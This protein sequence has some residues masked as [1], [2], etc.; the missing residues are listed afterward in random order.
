MKRCTLIYLVLIMSVCT[1]IFS[2]CES[3]N[4]TDGFSWTLSGT[5]VPGADQESSISAARVLVRN[6]DGSI[7]LGISD[8]FTLPVSGSVPFSITIDGSK[9]S[10]DY[11]GECIF[12]YIFNDV[13]ENGKCDEGE[14]LSSLSGTATDTV[15]PNDWVKFILIADSCAEIS[16]LSSGGWYVFLESQDEDHIS[17]KVIGNISGVSLVAFGFI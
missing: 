1:L 6:W 2:A 9:F 13:N 10:T 12:V 5:I 15:W 17:D 11:C 7:I 14:G 4:D 16:G 8:C 3:S